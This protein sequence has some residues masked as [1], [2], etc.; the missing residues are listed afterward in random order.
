MTRWLLVIIVERKFCRDRCLESTGGMEHEST[1]RQ[2]PPGEKQNYDAC[3][4]TVPRVQPVQAVQFRSTAPRIYFV[5][6]SEGFRAFSRVAP[7]RWEHLQAV[8]ET[9]AKTVN[10]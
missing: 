5:A 10:V 7:I 3:A 2:N 1:R 8:K 9:T 4:A 6:L